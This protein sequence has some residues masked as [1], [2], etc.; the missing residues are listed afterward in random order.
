MTDVAK[1]LPVKI[2][3]VFNAVD[4]VTLAAL[5]ALFRAMDY[6]AGVVAFVFPFNTTLM[7]ITFGIT[8]ITAAVIIRKPGVFTLFTLAAQLINVFVQGEMPVAGLIML[9]WGVLADLYLYFRLKNGIDPFKSLREMII[10]AVLMGIV[11]VVTVYGIL[12]PI[13]YLVQLST[14]IYVALMVVGWIGVVVGGILGFYLGS[15]I[16]GLLG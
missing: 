5:A 15:R 10:C 4:L 16:K 3:R 13:L 11:W 9:S 1:V 14:F 7:T 2:W 8:A 12:F 6:V